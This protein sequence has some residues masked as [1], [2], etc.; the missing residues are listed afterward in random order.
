MTAL[1]D[2]EGE[3]L[4][5]ADGLLDRAAHDVAKYMAMT[6][7][8]I[9]PEVAGERELSF[10]RQD[11]ERTDGARS[12]WAI[13]GELSQELGA[14]AADPEVEAIDQAM[15]ELEALL[16]AK[17]SQPAE[18]VAATLRAADQITALRRR[19]RGRRLE[20]ER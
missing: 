3:A 18:L 16:A 5:A 14:L 10:L 11:L 20:A 6:A 2:L 1:I 19:V 17:G 4:T 15:A 13:W 9:D 8:N 12:A 7:R